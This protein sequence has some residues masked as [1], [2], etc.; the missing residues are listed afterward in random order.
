MINTCQLHYGFSDDHTECEFICVLLPPIILCAVKSIE[1]TYI[2]PILSD[3][4]LPY[5]HLRDNVSWE[6]VILSSIKE[7]YDCRNNFSAP[8]S[9]QSLFYRMWTAVYDNAFSLPKTEAPANYHLSILKDML[10]YIQGNYMKKISLADIAKAGNISKNNCL[11]IFRKYLKTTPVTHLNNFRLQKSVNL[12]LCS[13]LIISEIAF[14]VGFSG[15]SYFT[16]M[17]HK[18]FGCTPSE[19]KNI[20]LH[21]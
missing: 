16:E 8:L 7:I 4:D 6:S 1:S 12:L 15:A 21:I 13:D 3:T 2:T 5:F 18:C 11:K 20:N 17:F 14:E 19:Y 10:F 9:I